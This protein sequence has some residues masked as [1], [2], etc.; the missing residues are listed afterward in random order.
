CNA[1][2]MQP[3]A[4]FRQILREC[5]VAIYGVVSPDPAAKTRPTGIHVA[6]LQVNLDWRARMA[7]LFFRHAAML[8][9][10][11][12]RNRSAR[13]VPSSTLCDGSTRA[14]GRWT[15]A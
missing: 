2:L 13:D 15:R 9:V 14:A 7:G 5:T 4:H 12:S 8:K 3:L 1:K 11:W 10:D 6:F